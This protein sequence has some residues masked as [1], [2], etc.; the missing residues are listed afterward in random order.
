MALESSE[1][2][3]NHVTYKH[4]KSEKIGIEHYII[5]DVPYNFIHGKKPK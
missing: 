5:T 1:M 4:G 2:Q 3:V